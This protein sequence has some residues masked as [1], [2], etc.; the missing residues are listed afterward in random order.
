MKMK[1]IVALALA[2]A[3]CLGMS[4]VALA[5]DSPQKSDAVQ[6]TEEGK[7]ILVGDPEDPAMSN[8]NDVA[9][10][11]PEKLDKTV[12]NTFKDQ[13]YELNKQLDDIDPD[14]IKPSDLKKL[15]EQQKVLESL[16]NDDAVYEVVTIADIKP[17]DGTVVNEKNPLNVRFNLMNGTLKNLKV[18]QTIRILHLVDGLWQVYETEVKL[19]DNGFYAEWAFKHF[20]PVAVF[21]V[22]SDNSV[23]PEPTPTPNPDEPTVTPDPDVNGSITADQ[24]ADLIV[25]KLQANANATKVV[26]TSVK[27]SP[28]TGE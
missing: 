6:A 2:G 19:D 22:N 23:T 1:K 10:N 9:K 15:Q 14:E 13:L 12:K 24:L 21:R 5:A 16:A 28:K 26:R 18:G 11:D 7:E 4:T 17:A 8:W 3:L 27:A 25:K 20:S